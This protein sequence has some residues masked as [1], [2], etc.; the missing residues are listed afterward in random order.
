MTEWLPSLSPT[1]NVRVGAGK[2]SKNSRLGT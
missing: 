1:M 2:M